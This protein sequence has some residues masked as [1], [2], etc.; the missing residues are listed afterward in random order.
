MMTHFLNEIEVNP[1]NCVLLFFLGG[2]KFKCCISLYSPQVCG[3]LFFSVC[4]AATKQSNKDLYFSKLQAECLKKTNIYL[5]T[6]S[7]HSG[8]FFFPGSWAVDH[9]EVC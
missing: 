6:Y 5:N 8:I 3:F 4:L 9:Q 2:W 1:L 7:M